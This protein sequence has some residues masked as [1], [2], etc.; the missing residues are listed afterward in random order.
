[1][2]PDDVDIALLKLPPYS[3]EAE[4]SVLG[5][6]M[7][8][9]DAWDAVA[10]QL[11]D[12]DFFRPEH[13]LIFR[14][15]AR[16]VETG[17]PIDIVTLSGAM[18]SENEMERVGGFKYLAEIAHSTPSAA[19][20][21]AYANVVRNRARARALI[22]I[23]QNI[24][25]LGFDESQPID[26]REELAQAALMQLGDT[27]GDD[28][29]STNQAL[30]DLI[31]R[32]DQRFSDGN[33]ITG[34][35]TGFVDIDKRTRG[36]QRG[37]LIL[38][39]GR[40]SMGKTTLAM[41]IVEHVAFTLRKSVLVFSMEMSQDELFEKMLAS[42]GHIR[43][44][45][46]QTGKFED[47]EWSYMSRAVSTMKDSPLIVDDRPA[48]SIQQMRSRARKLHKTNPLSLIVVDYL[49]LASV[50]ST[51]NNENR[52]QEISSISRGLKALAKELN[53]PVIAIAQLNRNCESRPNKR[54]INSDL[55]D[56]GQIEQD[57]DLICMMY[58]D[59]YYN[60]ETPDKGIAE[61]IW[62]K[63]RNGQCGTDYLAARLDQ[64]RF[65][66]LD[67]A[68]RPQ[69]HSNVTPISNRTQR[70]FEYE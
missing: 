23:G 4:Q 42:V 51:R 49:Q 34:L 70:G 46:I 33:E 21:R 48:L 14:R 64:S 36:L 41:N 29:V 16:L 15:M 56:S 65:L 19:N 54:P 25:E 27:R 52:E 30:K 20:V 1:M 7:I 2:H 39:A 62:R 61:A 47:E 11:S 57:A 31:D 22:T 5:G 24:A 40:P 43:L 66:T 18:E 50:K 69:H 38:I 58:R 55:R 60:A 53:C 9:N 68:S 32:I 8:A 26:D 44:S 10:E 3:L 13:Q 59:E 45:A 63:F 17:Q 35:T 6:L 67:Q 37:N 12:K 28:I